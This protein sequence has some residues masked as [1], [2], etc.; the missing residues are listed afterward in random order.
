[1][2]EQFAGV[3]WPGRLVSNA[4]GGIDSG[5]DPGSR[6]G[7]CA[8]GTRLQPQRLRFQPGQIL[9]FLGGEAADADGAQNQVGLWVSH[10]DGALH[11]HQLGVAKVGDVATLVFSRWASAS[12][13]E[14]DMAEV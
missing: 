5:H 10:H 14:P 13:S 1:M 3:Q 12:A 9:V 11:G 4:G 2:R 8:D 7:G 6:T